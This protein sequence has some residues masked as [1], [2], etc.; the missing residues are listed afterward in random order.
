MDEQTLC[1][2]ESRWSLQYPGACWVPFN[3][4]LVKTDVVTVCAG[5]RLRLFFF[6]LFFFL[7]VL[8]RE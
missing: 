4:T 6:F 2:G 7:V 1:L 3:G 5:A 8:C